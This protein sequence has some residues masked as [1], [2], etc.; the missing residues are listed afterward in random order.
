[1]KYK[2]PDLKILFLH[3]ST[4]RNIWYGDVNENMCMVPRLLK[5]YNDQQGTKISIEERNFP[6]GNPY[7]WNN[8]PYDY[9]NIWVKHA[10]D[11]PYMEEPTLEILTKNYDII[12]F[13]HCFPVSS[14]LEDD[15]LPD[16]DSEKKTLSNYKLQ[17]IAIKEKLLEFP[18]TEFIIWTGAALIESQTN[19]VEAKRANEFADWVKNQWNETNDNIH[20]FDFRDIETEGGLYLKPEYAAGTNDSHPNKMLSIKAARLFVKK[21]VNAIENKNTNL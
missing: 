15:Q 10:G 5:E 11:K 17:Y 6:Q 12:I 8:Y 16:I 3:H 18:Q 7:S 13:K 21:I 19:I 4:G 9:Y 1:L 14:I 20:V 2:D